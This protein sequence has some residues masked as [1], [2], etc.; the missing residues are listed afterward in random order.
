MITLPS[1]VIMAAGLGSRFGGIKQLAHVGENGEIL[2]DYSIY[3]ALKSGFSKVVFVIRRDIEKD[4]RD[5]VGAKYENICDTEYVFQDLSDIPQ[6]FHVPADRKK[7]WGTCH[8]V[9]SCRNVIKEPFAVINADDFYGRDS[10]VKLYDYLSTSND[11]SSSNICL[12]GYHLGNTLS[13]SGGVT[14]GICKTDEDGNLVSITETANIKKENGMITSDNS[15]CLTDDDF[16]SMNM[17]GLQ[18]EFIGLL[19]QGFKEF[20]SKLPPD[21]SGEFLLP[22]YIDSLI[23]S[24]R[25]KAKLLPSSDSWF[26]LTYKEDLPSVQSRIKELCDHGIYPHDLISSL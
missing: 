6:G 4:F 1:L 9:L 8:A 3:D 23:K 7:P 22:I 19:D 20:L 10:F 13:E 12:A 15:T 5:I 11:T 18:Q 25:A 24:G 21:G 17:W 2:M 16:V 14:R 26:G